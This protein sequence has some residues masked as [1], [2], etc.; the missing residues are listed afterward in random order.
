MLTGTSTLLPPATEI[1]SV[2]FTAS[3]VLASAVTVTVLPLT[4]APSSPERPDAVRALSP[5]SATVTATVFVP[6]AASKSIFDG[7][8]VVISGLVVVEPP[9][10]P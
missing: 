4:V 10:S 8:T 2:W 9:P 1:V 6:P 7:S 5:W 3:P